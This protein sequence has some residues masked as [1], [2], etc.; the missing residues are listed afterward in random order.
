MN[1]LPEAGGGE[2]AAVL[3]RFRRDFHGC[4]TA[5]QDSSGRCVGTPVGR[6][7]HA[8]VSEPTATPRAGEGPSEPPGRVRTAQ[9]TQ[10]FVAL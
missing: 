7:V 10:P 5:R 2:P 6:E 8:D 9:A 1:T 4:L 3:S